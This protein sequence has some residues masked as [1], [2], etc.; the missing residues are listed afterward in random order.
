MSKQQGQ[1]LKP[2][3][4][5]RILEEYT[6]DNHGITMQRI[7]ELLAMNGVKAERKSIYEDFE[8][9]E[10]FGCE[11]IAEKSRTTEYHLAGRQFELVELK[12]LIDSI[13]SSKFLPEDKTRSIIK[14]LQT[15]CSVYEAHSL[16]R[17]VLVTNRV[18]SMNKTPH[19]NLDAIHEAISTNKQISAKYFEYDMDKRRR[20]YKK[21]ALYTLSPFALVYTDDNYYLFALEAGKEKIKAFRVDRMDSAAVLPLE[22]QESAAFAKI[23]MSAYTK[24]TFSMYGGEMEDVTM[25]FH[26]RLMNAVIDKFGRDVQ[27]SKEDNDH[28]RITV[29]IAVSSQFFGWVFG[30]GK[31]ARIVEPESVKQQMRLAIK[32]AMYMHCR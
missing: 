4:L 30:L 14:K 19:Y 16:Q 28:F 11:V 12:L 15:L 6:D 25:V 17:Q 27:V 18:K 29:P 2:L 32:D 5:K 20:Y 3:Y 31:M 7:L 1:K 21:G 9:L 24:Y 22:R 23:D 10:Q 13:Q 26:R 8:A